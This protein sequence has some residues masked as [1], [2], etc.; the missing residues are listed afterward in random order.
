MRM[1]T[2]VSNMNERLSVKSQNLRRSLAIL[3]SAAL[4]SA[5]PSA[6]ATIRTWTA[7]SGNWSNGSNWSP[8]G[9]PQNGDDLV[10]NNS[11]SSNL[12]NDIPGL[13]VRTL[14][15]HHSGAVWGL[16]LTVTVGISAFSVDSGPLDMNFPFLDLGHDISISSNDGTGWGYALNCV[17]RLNGFT[18]TVYAA[19]SGSVEFHSPITGNGQINFASGTNYLIF[20]DASAGPAPIEVSA[21]DLVLAS[22]VGQFSVAGRL[23]IDPGALVELA[24]NYQ[25]DKASPV[26]IE[27]GATLRL[28]DHF[29]YFANLEMRGGLLDSGPN[30]GALFLDYGQFNFNTTNETAVLA[31]NFSGLYVSNSTPILHVN[32][33]SNPSLDVQAH[34]TANQIIKAGLGLTRLSASN[35]FYQLTI[36]QGVVEADHNFALGNNSFVLLTDGGLSLRSVSIS[37]VTLTAYSSSKAQLDGRYGCLLTCLNTCL[38][39]GPISLNTNLFIFLA[40]D[41]TVSGPITGAG[42]VSF[43][44]GTAHLTGTSGNTFTGAT[45]SQCQLLELGKPSGVNAYAGPLFVGGGAGVGPFEVRWLQSYQNVGATATLYANGVI[46]LNNHNEDFGPVTFNGGEVDTGAGAFNIYAPLTVNPAPTSATIN[47]YLGLPPGADRVFI[48]GDGAADCDLLVNAV[49][50]GSPGTYFVKQGA[51]TMCLANANTF[52]APTLLETGILDINSDQGLGIWPGLIIFN[53]ATLRISGPGN[54]GGGVEMLGT[55]VGGTHGAI[56]VLPGNG[57]TISGSVLLDAS[58]T[59]NLGGTLGLSGAVSGTGPLNKTGTGALVFGGGVNNTYSGDTVVSAGSLLLAKSANHICV[60]GNLVIG[61]GPAGPTTFAR[62]FQTGAIGGTTVTVNANSL[63]DLNGYYQALTTLNLR[64]GGSVHTGVG[65]LDFPSGGAI[66]V[67]S[68]NA[69]GSHVS[70]AITGTLGLPPNATLPFNINPFAPFFPFASG[71]ELDLTATIPRPTENLSFAPAGITKN[72]DGQ[73]RLSGNN[74]Y[75]GSSFIND[76]TLTVDGTQPQS[77]ILV[78]SGTLAGSGTVGLI[79]MNGGVV[80]PGDSG[81]GILTCSNLNAGISA[82]GVLRMELNGTTPGTGYDQLNVHGTVNLAGVTLQPVLGFTAPTG[83]QFD[84]ISND[85]NDAVTGTFNGLPDGKKLYI[86]GVLYQVNYEFGGKP[87]NDVALQGLDTPP[88]PRLLIEKIPPAS[89]R[90]LWP[91]NDP[92]FSLQTTTNLLATNWLAALPL[93]AVIGTNNVVTNSTTNAQRFYRLSNP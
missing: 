11:P 33:P 17:T 80:A 45:I 70:A 91:T 63:F 22:Y 74:T 48:V 50:F 27:P 14:E 78:N 30:G 79:Y 86:G 10:F 64:D 21:G 20:H 44:S 4:F 59:L 89:V 71:P 60:P 28:N 66:N 67:G 90:L 18:L 7:G 16:S 42:G 26:L 58:T 36:A 65:L 5:A 47:G 25:I 88:P 52:N 1:Q 76:G 84:I 69:F 92:P 75:A 56:E 72:G 2:Q 93:P 8:N 19:N 51:G 83:A 49:V 87:G 3:M 34:L 31:G 85:G 41:L 46:N 62:L 32:G 37:G 61:P 55:G 35:S 23:Q 57:F 81:P 38:W 54:T 68:L 6:R 24:D 29:C 77:P 39:S 9:A 82:S 13:S 43:W 15:F 12:T 73:M 40:G 53:G